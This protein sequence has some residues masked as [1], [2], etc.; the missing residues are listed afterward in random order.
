VILFGLGFDKCPE[1]TEHSGTRVT[2]I[3]TPEEEA[4]FNK[5]DESWKIYFDQSPDVWLKFLVPGDN[6]ENSIKSINSL[7]RAELQSSKLSMIHAHILMEIKHFTKIHLNV[8]KLRA[9]M[10]AAMGHH[11][12][13]D[14]KVTGSRKED[15]DCIKAYILK[16]ETL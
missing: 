11:I 5:F 12:H 3:L 6:T 2:M 16:E 15:L 8:D 14:N 4:Y 10:E 1:G 9:Y 13:I 7:A